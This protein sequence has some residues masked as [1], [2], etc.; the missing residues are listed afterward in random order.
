MS[1]S[2]R[3]GIPSGPDNPLRRSARWTA[4]R[5]DTYLAV[6]TAAGN[7]RAAAEAIGMD[8]RTIEHRREKDPGFD[9]DC[10]AA[11]AEADRRLKGEAAD[12]AARGEAPA[13]PDPFEVI[14]TGPRGRA[15][16]A[17]AG[18]GRWSG[19]AEA[20]FLAELRRTGN[21]SASVRAAGFS[22]STVSERRRKWPAFAQRI[23]E[24]LEDAELTLEFRL[25]AIAND[26]AEE[27]A[28]SGEESGRRQDEFDREFALRFLKWREEKRRRSGDGQRS[29]GAD[30]WRREITIE[31]ARD[32]VIARIAAIKRHRERD[33]G[34]EGKA[35]RDEEGQ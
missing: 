13:G 17:A 8:R 31:E 20:V 6:L 19:R 4:L 10:Q 26:V 22:L 9:R 11:L 21:F 2:E 7:A 23:E 30:R 18:K 32:E 27:E 25:A 34:G 35:P 5:R 12:A 29:G 24:A 28:E 1:I 33:G 16:I 3:K 15:Q 14:R